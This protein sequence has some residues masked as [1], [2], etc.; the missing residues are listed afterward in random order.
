MPWVPP[1]T[2]HTCLSGTTTYKS[3]GTT[4]LSGPMG[5]QRAP[6]SLPPRP[7]TEGQAEGRA[8]RIHQHRISSHSEAEIHVFLVRKSDS[9]TSQSRLAAAPEDEL[10]TRLPSGKRPPLYLFLGEESQMSRCG[11]RWLPWRP[12]QH[13]AASPHCAPGRRPNPNSLSCYQSQ[14]SHSSGSRSLRGSQM[15]LVCCPPKPR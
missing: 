10:L 11:G 12:D 4:D 13:R 7:D 3:P 15:P 5:S 2:P 6:Q 14:T 9:I 1:L 8:R